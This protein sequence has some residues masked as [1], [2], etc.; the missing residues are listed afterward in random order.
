MA[1]VVSSVASTLLANLATKSFQEII[2]AYG[3]KDEIKKFESSLR[4]IDAY[5]IDAENKQAKNHSIDEWLK[6]LRE[7]FDDAGDILDEIEYEAK[8]NEVVKIYGSISIKVRRFFSYTS[9]PL[10]F[11]IKMAHKI[12]DMKQKMD[13]K[14]K[15]GRN[16]GIIEQ[17]V[18]TPALEHN[19]PWR[20]TASSLSFRV[21]GRLEEKEE[22]INSL[23]TQKL[24]ANSIDVISI[25]GIGGL[26]K[27]TLAQMVYNDTQVKANFDTLM[28]VCV[29]DDFD[30]KKLIQKIIHAASKR[31]NVVDANSSLEYMI[32]LL[33]QNLHGKKF[34]LVL[35]DVW[36]ENHNKWDELRT[37][38]LE[39]AG[40]K[41]SKIIVTTRSQKVVD[42]VGSNLVMKL[43]GLP[44][45]ECWRLFVKCA[46]QEEKE[47]EKYPRLK[48]IGEQIVKKCKGVPLAITTL[49]CLLRSKSHDENQWRKIM[50]NEVWNLSQEE[51]DILPSLKLSYNHLPPQVKQC[52][53]YCS[54]FPKDYDFHVIELI[55]F[56][57]AHGLLQPT[58]EDEDA[59]DIG[60]LYIKKL[61]STS[62]LQIHDGDDLF[63]LFDFQNLM[64]FKRLKMHDLVHDL[65]QL[66]MKESS[67]TRTI[68]QEGQ[69][70][71][72]IE[73]ASNKFNYLRVLH[74]RKDMELMSSL[75]DDCFV[76]MKKHLRYLYLENCP[77]LKKLT[78][79][80][81]KM[82]NLQSLYLDEFPKNMKN[83]IY[84]Q[85]LFLMGIKITSLSSMNI[86]CFQQLKFLY[87]QCPK[88]VSVPSVV[89]RMTT[90]KKLGFLWCEEL[91]N[92]EDEE[93]EGKQHVVVN[94]LNL[95]LF[96]I[97]GSKK[98]NALPK[99]LERATKL[100][101]LSISITGIKS[102]PTRLSMTSLE[103]LYIY[104]C[105][106]LS[107]LPNMD[108][109]HHLQYLVVYDCP[110]LYARYNK[111]TG[112]DWSKIAHIP[113]CKIDED[114][115]D[116]NDDD[117]HDDDEEFMMMMKMMIE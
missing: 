7:A 98:L 67:K 19:L 14:I 40:D 16:L 106:N 68:V 44:E 108:Q 3:L 112:P 92:F 56:W 102:L 27:T 73:W 55:M 8:R 41:N 58:R 45:N 12:K 46:F 34:L 104:H 10:A 30:V 85:Y 100:Q 32:S 80:I 9:N 47:E 38:L 116:D 21:C 26:G 60:E 37:H 42:I 81:Y 101:Y 51:T 77:N 5:L 13:E 11:R 1:E 89:G 48:Q 78:D 86:G 105:K 63:R 110:A 95:Q 18:N 70:E 115:D 29:S 39:A 52:F 113:Y 88:L 65:A 82:Q 114:D 62:L 87:L 94:N 84:L 53:S 74:L 107:S 71:A 66:T 49:G 103:E 43:E 97:I 17:H 23:M 109:T 96:L 61:V 50:D 117:D 35:D 72:S 79:S 90:L 31:E 93:E 15:E 69:Q 64:T 24:E 4:T 25:V 6:Q 33:N 36:N 99:W 83:L 111:E 54:C 2:L 28:W 22:I 75:P 91:I 20:E 76:K 59:E 57:M